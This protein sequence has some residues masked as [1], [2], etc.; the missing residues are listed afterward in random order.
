MKA[1][2]AIEMLATRNPDEEILIAHWDKEW[3]IDVIGKDITDDQWWDILGACENVLDYIGIGDALE[4]AAN[5]VL[6]GEK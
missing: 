1:K 6:D 2:H 3:F 4:Q 5:E